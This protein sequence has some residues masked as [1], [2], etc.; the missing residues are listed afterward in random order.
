MS[1]TTTA[2]SGGSGGHGDDDGDSAV[3][4]VIVA[5]GSGKEEA[6]CGPRRFTRPP[7]RVEGPKSAFLFA[8][9][10][11]FCIE[12]EVLRVRNIHFR[13]R[14]RFVETRERE[15]PVKYHESTSLRAPLSEV[16]RKLRLYSRPGPLFPF[17]PHNVN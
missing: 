3:V 6:R 7:E 14:M 9:D 5:G 17:L 16:V 15:L 12:E 4:A 13:G 2:S 11:I 1:T 8:P 10:V